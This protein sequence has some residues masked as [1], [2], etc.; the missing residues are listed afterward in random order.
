MHPLKILSPH[1][2]KEPVLKALLTRLNFLLRGNRRLASQGKDLGTLFSFENL[3]DICRFHR[4]REY[5]W[6]S[7]VRGRL[8][9]TQRFGLREAEFEMPFY[10]I[11]L[12]EF[13]FC[14]Y[15]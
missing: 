4:G 6:S 3:C 15:Y 12:F 5:R 8:G 10:Y 9:I 1:A 13:D 2:L 7:E 11:L 14:L